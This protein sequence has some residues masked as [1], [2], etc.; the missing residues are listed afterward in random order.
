MNDLCKAVD[1]I[2]SLADQHDTQ[3]KDSLQKLAS[4]A[5][6]CY[7][8]AGETFAA[9]AARVESFDVDVTQSTADL[10]DTIANLDPSEQIC[11]PLIQLRERIESDTPEEYSSTG[12]TPPRKTYAVSTEIP[13]TERR[14]E[15]LARLRTEPTTGTEDAAPPLRTGGSNTGLVFADPPTVVDEAA[16]STEQTTAS[17]N[18]ARGLGL[19]EL[20]PNAVRLTEPSSVGIPLPKKRQR[21]VSAVSDLPLPKTKKRAG[22]PKKGP[23]NSDLPGGRASN[24]ALGPRATRMAVPR[25][26]RSS[27]KTGQ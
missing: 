24:A 14:E 18:N 11:Q 21:V 22:A 15:L 6:S 23:E 17:G 8:G 2:E 16:P 7:A 20:D 26:L 3:N 5:K 13:R 10:K 27:R 1:G 12:R 9:S 4:T 25:S 19:R